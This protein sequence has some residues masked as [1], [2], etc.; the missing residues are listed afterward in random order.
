MTENTRTPLVRIASGKKTARQIRQLKKG[1]GKLVG[2][3]D[4][5]LVSAKETVGD[6]NTIEVPIVVHFEVEPDFSSLFN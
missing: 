2:Q 4:G 6:A 3:I 5:Q 1:R